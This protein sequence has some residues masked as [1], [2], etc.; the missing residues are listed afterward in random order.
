LGAIRPKNSTLSAGGYISMVEA[1]NVTNKHNEVSW[2]LLDP[3]YSEEPRAPRSRLV[4]IAWS[5]LSS[6]PKRTPLIS[7]L[8]D[9]AAMSVV[10][11]ASGCGKTFLTLDL[12]AHVA[13]GWNW[14]GRKLK[15][16]TVLYIAAEGG[17]GIEERL[18]AFRLKHDINVADVPLHVIPEPVDLCGSA[19]DSAVLIQRCESLS[20]VA[21]IVIDT[22]SRAMAGGNENSPDDMGKFVANCDRLRLATGAHVLVIHHAGKDEGRGA[23]GHSLLKAAA[24]TEI[25]VAKDDITGIATAKVAKQRDHRTDEIFAF[26]LL[27]FEIGHDDDGVPITSCV[28]EPEDA[29]TVR[30]STTSRKL[31]DRQRLA[32]DA[33]AECMATVGKPAPASL[34]L[35]AGILVVPIAAWREELFVRRVLERDAPSPREDFR[36]VRNGLQARAII[37]VHGD[38]VWKAR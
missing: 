26:R 22:L 2:R 34:Q 4:P 6:L 17:L 35:P 20:P 30:R 19:A 15:Q 27:P 1:P 28:V 32:L 36:R 10:Y 13:L 16:G 31:S 14:R 11:G 23:R 33:L 8:L 12:A 37:G 38:L 5:E 21:L 3:D 25:E 24:D 9:A 18:T 29:A 7:G